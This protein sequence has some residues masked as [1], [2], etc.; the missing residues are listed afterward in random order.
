MCTVSINTIDE[1]EQAL[2]RLQELKD[3]RAGSP[4][5]SELDALVEAIDQW[6]KRLDDISAAQLDR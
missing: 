4:E 3:A 2:R 5:D 6:D 1:Y